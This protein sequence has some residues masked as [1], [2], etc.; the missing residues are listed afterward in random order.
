[1]RLVLL[2]LMAACSWAQA[3]FA[4]RKHRQGGRARGGL[5]GDP[6]GGAGQV[7]ALLA[8]S[9]SFQAGLTFDNVIATRQ[10]ARIQDL[11]GGNLQR[12]FTEEYWFSG[13][14]GI[15]RP[16]TT[17]SFLFNYIV[18]G[19]GAALNRA[20]RARGKGESETG[21]ALLEGMIPD[22]NSQRVAAAWRDSGKPDQA[23]ATAQ[24]GVSA[25]GCPANLFP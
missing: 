9:N 21:L 18:P 11:T 8:Y 14:T 13:A 17:L 20:S 7:A 22:R 15:Y 6:F 3:G 1:M 2:A 19:D 12:I 5:L 24:F 25:L 4:I 23:A 10:D 16:L